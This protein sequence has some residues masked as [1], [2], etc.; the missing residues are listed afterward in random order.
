MA[1]YL[2]TKDP[3]RK[4][5]DMRNN[6]SKVVDTKLTYKFEQLF[7]VNNAFAKKNQK[8]ISFIIALKC[9]DKQSYIIENDQ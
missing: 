9:L 2:K 4:L 6:L 7:C 1:I 5:L 3:S 8:I